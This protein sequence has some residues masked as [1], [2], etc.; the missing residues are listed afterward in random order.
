MNNVLRR[1]FINLSLTALL[2]FPLACLS[3]ET[4]SVIGASDCK[5]SNVEQ[6]WN[7]ADGL[8]RENEFVAAVT[9]YRTLCDLDYAKGCRRLG[10]A[11]H[12]GTGVGADVS[13]A[14]APYEKGCELKDGRACNNLGTLHEE[15][16]IKGASIKK[17]NELYRKSC[18]LNE[19]MGCSNAGYNFLYGISG[20]VVDTD[21]GIALL[22]Q[23]CGLDSAD[24]CTEIADY[25]DELT[26]YKESFLYYQK[27]CKLED[28]H[29][30]LRVGWY[31]DHGHAVDEDISN[32]NIHYRLSCELGNPSGC[33]NYG[34]ALMHVDT[35][36]PKIEKNEA[37][38]LEL[39]V[40]ACQQEEALACT[41][42]GYYHEYT[43]GT[44]E[45]I[46]TALK[47]YETGCTLDDPHSGSCYN[48]GLNY[49]YGVGVKKSIK[50]AKTYMQRACELGDEDGCEWEP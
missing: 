42:A 5:Q 48:L 8:D 20:T 38:G 14:I 11:Y 45:D 2:Y 40:W 23:G 33:N 47:F 12:T 22:K 31:Y 28:G 49:E 25:F 16:L 4:G 30:C 41:G 15:E 46:K 39:L 3:A 17:A 13:K 6:C 9:Y 32:A 43:L 10:W 50:K 21:A 36:D 27:A 37:Q 29:G 26:H 7:I 19:E 18:D 44:D 1:L 34:R 35:I 24:Q